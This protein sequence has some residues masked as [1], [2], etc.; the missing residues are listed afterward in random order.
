MKKLAILGDFNPSSETHI[1]TNS[2]IEHS[3]K[4]LGINL[5]VS[6]ISTDEISE[7]LL[8]LFNGYLVAPGSP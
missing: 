1:A 6:W 4:M 7:N 5:D 3:K 2:A 8:T